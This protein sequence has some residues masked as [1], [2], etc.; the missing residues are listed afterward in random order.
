[1][2]I[3]YFLATVF[4]FATAVAKDVQTIMI[5]R[6][7]TGFFGAAPITNVGGALSDIWAPQHRGAA[8]VAY[9][10]TLIAGTVLAPI[11]GGAIVVSGLDWR[12]AEYV[13]LLLPFYV[14]VY[15]LT[16]TDHW[17]SHVTVSSSWGNL[18]R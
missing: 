11:V 9:A 2:L 4:S 16:T 1:V 6:F 7:F 14:K 12:W 18:D 10:V 17:D 15:V 8:I 3:P 5:T 13:R